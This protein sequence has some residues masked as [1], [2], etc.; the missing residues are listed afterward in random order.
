MEWRAMSA[1]SRILD[2]L[3]A[4]GWRIGLGIK[5]EGD[6]P[7]PPDLLAELHGEREAVLRALVEETLAARLLRQAEAAA[8]ALAAP[9]PDREAERAVMVQHYAAP[10]SARPYLPSDPDPLRD[11]LLAAARQAEAQAPAPETWPALARRVEAF[12]A[13]GA[14][15]RRADGAFALTA[16]DGC[17]MHLTARG[18]ALLPPAL[19][20]RLERMADA[21]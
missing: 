4:G 2:R 10:P 16:A 14:E 6:A 3:R 21:T 18:L 19:V 8:A 9:D 13:A 7:P 12:L 20:E 15:V 1:P 5:I 17:A 11:G